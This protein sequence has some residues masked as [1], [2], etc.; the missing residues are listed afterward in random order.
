[1]TFSGLDWPADLLQQP[2]A[3]VVS[4]EYPLQRVLFRGLRVRVGIHTGLPE[5]IVVRFKKSLPSSRRRVCSQQK[6]SMFTLIVLTCDILACWAL[7]CLRALGTESLTFPW[8]YGPDLL[9]QAVM[10]HDSDDSQ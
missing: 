2:A 10:L 5:Q 3:A 4:L 1:M 7:C 6:G 9:A 8:D